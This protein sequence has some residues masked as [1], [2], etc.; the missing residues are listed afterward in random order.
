[1]NVW[2]AKIPNAGDRVS[3]PGDTRDLVVDS[4]T[5]LATRDLGKRPQASDSAI[6]AIVYV[7]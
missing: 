5:H 1:M 7:H 4:V 2:V 3:L 6:S